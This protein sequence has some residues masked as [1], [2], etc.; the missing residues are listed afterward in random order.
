MGFSVI[1]ESGGGVE[2]TS[3]HVLCGY[4][5]QGFQEVRGGHFIDVW[6]FINR[7]NPIDV[8]VGNKREPNAHRTNNT[9]AHIVGIDVYLYCSSLLE[10]MESMEV[11]I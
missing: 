1:D 7:I 9:T 8:N 2:Y 5:G 10:S 4:I 3:G 6:G 11:L